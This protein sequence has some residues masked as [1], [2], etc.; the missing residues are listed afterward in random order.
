[1]NFIDAITGFTAKRIVNARE[2]Y[3]RA[4]SNSRHLIPR[5]KLPVHIR[6]ESVLHGSDEELWSEDWLVRYENELI[7]KMALTISWIYSDIDLIARQCSAVGLYGERHT[8]NNK[9][10]KLNECP[11]VDLINNPNPFMTKTYLL[12]T[13]IYW[14]QISNRGAFLYLAPEIGN[15]Q[16]ILE[17]W[18]IN[19]NQMRVVRTKDK[20][21]KEYR[22]YPKRGSGGGY[23]HGYH[24]INPKYVVWLRYPDP[25]FT[26]GSLPP[27][28]AAMRSAEISLGIIES[29]RKL[30]VESKG[31]PLT[32]VSVDPNI[33][34]PDFMTVKRDIRDDWESGN[35][36]I[37]VTRAGDIS[38]DSLGFTQKDL[39]TLQAQELSRDEIDSVFFGY[40]IRNSSAFDGDGIKEGNRLLVDQ[41]IYPLLVL[42]QEHFTQ[43]IQKRFF[44][45][46]IKIKFDDVRLYDKALQIQEK[47]VQS[48]YMTVNE[49]RELDGLAPLEIDGVENIGNYLTSLANHPQFVT[50]NWGLNMAKESDDTASGDTAIGNNGGES[51]DGINA[52]HVPN[53]P[54][55][56][57]ISGSL[58]PEATANRLAISDSG[59]KMALNLELKQRK[60]V[61]QKAL[62]SGEP[63]PFSYEIIPTEIQDQIELALEHCKSAQEIDTLFDNIRTQLL[64]KHIDNNK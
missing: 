47:Q 26:H 16:N 44:D 39:E 27:L 32:L 17:I 22:Y 36:T 23:G 18:P 14:L 6:A 49:M 53:L 25:F 8:T 7:Q 30:F 52:G 4:V 64:L 48:R 5:A 34:N 33:N 29:Q 63:R 60:K 46:T 56:G 61:A 37:A 42:I 3:A 20:F 58:A 13:I 45:P 55:V 2:S 19:P 35:T 51:D 12:R 10:E 11:V 31:L 1:M 15:S 40:P 21:V 24:R 50:V 62:K 28:Q 54:E 38:I 59:L 41:T 57:N 43:E 9:V